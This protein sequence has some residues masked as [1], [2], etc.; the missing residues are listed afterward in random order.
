MTPEPESRQYGAETKWLLPEQ[1]QV[2]AK[3]NVRTYGDGEAADGKLSDLA[4]TIERDGQLDAGI[5]YASENGDTVTYTLVAGHR[6]R[7]AIAL[8]NESRSLSGQPLLRMRV[9]VDHNG[10][11]LRKAIVSNL[12]REDFSPMDLAMIINRLRYAHDW[13]GGKGTAKIAEYLAISRQQVMEHEKFL[14]ADKSLQDRLHAGVLSWQS[15]AELTRKKLPPDKRQEVLER[16]EEIQ[17]EEE[18]RKPVEK[19]Q[20]RIQHP[21]VKRAIRETTDTAVARSRREI[22]EWVEA[23]DGPAYGA[24]VAEWARYMVDQWAKGR[25]SDRTLTLKFAAMLG[26]P[27]RIRHKPIPSYRQSKQKK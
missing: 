6:R 18:A 11:P 14:T 7:R 5:V 13:V 17:A 27:P 24:K 4:A 20:G 19:R 22:L 25:G 10:D 15:A 16:A 2:D 23:L 21:A 26:P 12:H 1:I 8:L 9:I 3:F